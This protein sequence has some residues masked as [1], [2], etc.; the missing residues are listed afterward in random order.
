MCGCVGRLV[1]LCHFVWLRNEKGLPIGR[2]R[3]LGNIGGPIGEGRGTGVGTIVGRSGFV[4]IRGREDVATGS[5]TL[6]VWFGKNVWLKGKFVGR[7]SGG[8]RRT[9]LV[10][11]TRLLDDDDLRGRGPLLLVEAFAFAV[12]GGHDRTGVTKSGLVVVGITYEP[13]ENTRSGTGSVD[14]DSI[15][16]GAEVEMSSSWKGFKDPAE[17]VKIGIGSPG[18]S[19]VGVGSVT[20]SERCWPDSRKGRMEN[21]STL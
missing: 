19:S 15:G 2:G 11:R 8:G 14:S 3:W 7:V 17:P 5:T 13:F 16:P 9:D 1:G 6:F 21:I 18:T 4:R 12:G 20:L 10:G